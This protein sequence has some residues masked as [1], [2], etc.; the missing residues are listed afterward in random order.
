MDRLS[1]LWMQAG[2]QAGV[3]TGKQYDLL[4]DDSIDFIKS[5][6]LA[7]E[8]DFESKEVGAMKGEC[9]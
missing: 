4:F 9:M 6:M 8:G 2:A 5:A 3:S 1:L 7:G